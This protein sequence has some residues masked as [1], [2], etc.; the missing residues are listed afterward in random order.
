MGDYPRAEALKRGEDPAP[1]LDAGMIAHLD[2]MRLEAMRPPGMDAD[3]SRWVERLTNDP[4]AR[5]RSELAHRAGISYS[6]AVERWE[7]PQ[8]L[9]AEYARVAL[10]IEDRIERCGACGTRPDE[11]LDFTDP[12][13]AP[14]TGRTTVEAL[15]VRL[16]DVHRFGRPQRRIEPRGT[17][18]GRTV[19]GQATR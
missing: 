1:V 6:A 5:L 2:A 7:D 19:G 12:D 13:P 15:P 11:V 10:E 18:P 3:I 14:P 4:E 16:L 17:N 9:A 8:D